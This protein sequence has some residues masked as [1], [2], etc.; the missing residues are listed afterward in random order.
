LPRAASL[1]PTT[2]RGFA[3]IT[4]ETHNPLENR[5]RYRIGHS[6]ESFPFADGMAPNRP[7]DEVM[8]NPLAVAIA[9]QARALYTAREAALTSGPRLAAVAEASGRT[10]EQVLDN[11]KR[12]T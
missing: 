5:P 2:A 9:D 4:S 12:A 10:V 8:A 7:L 3:G 1:I 11:I 6:F